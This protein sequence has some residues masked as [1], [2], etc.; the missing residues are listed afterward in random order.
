MRQNMTFST[1][2]TKNFLGRGNSPS[3]TI[4][5]WNPSPTPHPPRRLRH[6]DP[7]HSIILVRHWRLHTVPDAFADLFGSYIGSRGS[8]GIKNRGS[9]HVCHEPKH[10][11]VLD[12]TSDFCWGGACSVMFTRR[13]VVN[14]S[15]VWRV[16][17]SNKKVPRDKSIIQWPSSKSVMLLVMNA[18]NRCIYSCTSR[19]AGGAIGCPIVSLVASMVWLF[20]RVTSIHCLAFHYCLA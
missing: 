19:L 1:K 13:F 17:M 12:T 18:L 8:S 15:K 20:Y 16:Y 11:S 6:L 9:A 5:Q 3:K 4:P 2:N 14:V 7:S 10:K